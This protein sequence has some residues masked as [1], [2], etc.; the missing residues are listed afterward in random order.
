MI[1]H[2]WLEQ[3]CYARQVTL[4]QTIIVRFFLLSKTESLTSLPTPLYLRYPRE[5]TS[6]VEMRLL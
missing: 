4:I 3:E 1:Q 5:T 6:G 2:F